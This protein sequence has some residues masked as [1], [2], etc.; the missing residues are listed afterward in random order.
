MLA[1]WWF[2]VI[3]Q[4]LSPLP[5]LEMPDQPTAVAVEAA[6]M[7]ALPTCLS[8]V[9]GDVEWSDRQFEH[10]RTA[11]KPALRPL[12]GKAVYRT[13]LSAPS[14]ARDWVDSYARDWRVGT[15]YGVEA[16]RL[17]NTQV[18]VVFGTG[19]RLQP[20]VD[21]GVGITGPV[22]RASLDLRQR[23]GEHTRLSQQTYLETGRNNNTFVR[24]AISF[25]VEIR[26]QVTLRSGVETRHV[27][28]GGDGRTET[29]GSVKLQ[30][31]F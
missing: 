12:P 15:R 9:C 27:A 29:E 14:S 21:D 10:F 1:A 17:P 3:G 7:S 23:L 30:Y 13:R 31:A 11:D 5:L 22:A 25:D 26:P 24:N 28:S 2:A 6:R 18:K 20:W 4:P 16:V 19:Y 8:L